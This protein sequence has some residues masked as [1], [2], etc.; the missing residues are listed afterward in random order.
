MRQ[1]L[2]A[3]AVVLLGIALVGCGGRGESSPVA[4]GPPQPVGADSPQ[5]VV[6]RVLTAVKDGDKAAFEACFLPGLPI[7]H[8]NRSLTKML[9]QGSL[10]GITWRFTGEK[11]N[12]RIFVDFSAPITVNGRAETKLDVLP[13]QDTD[14]ERVIMLGRDLPSGLPAPTGRWVII[15]SGLRQSSPNPQGAALQ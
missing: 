3:I 11:L 14:R 5:A 7:A 2:L 1:S 8:A 15:A 9:E 6:D 10:K 13:G 12:D 4:K